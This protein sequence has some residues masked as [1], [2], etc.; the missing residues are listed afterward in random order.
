M[1]KGF[2]NVP[3]PK[4]EPVL[5]YA[6]GSKERVLLKK[7]LEEARAKELDVPM[8]IGGQQIRSVS[9]KKLSPPHDHQ[10]VLGYFHEGDKSHVEQAIQAALNAKELWVNLG[11]EHR[12]SVFLKAA[13]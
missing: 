6:P 7:A 1:P 13:E 8:H 2:Y 10:H 5:S 3:L 11:W 12:A 9:K 4:N